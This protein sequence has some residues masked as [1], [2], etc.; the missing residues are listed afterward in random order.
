MTILSRPKTLNASGSRRACRIAISRNACSLP[1]FAEFA[2]AV[3]YGVPGTPL[4][5]P[6]VLYVIHTYDPRKSPSADL[7]DLWSDVLL[8]VNDPDLISVIV[9][10]MAPKFPTFD[11]LLAAMNTLRDRLSVDVF[12]GSTLD[13]LSVDVFE[14]STVDGLYLRHNRIPRAYFKTWAG[15]MPGRQEGIS[16][17]TLR[18]LVMAGTKPAEAVKK[19][20]VAAKER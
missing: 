18:E 19:S 6:V 15:Q 9:L 5:R 4:Q 1:D 17:R 13:G 2:Q 7:R 11:A 10:V 14:G 12:E 20:L 3:Q 16:F 8:N